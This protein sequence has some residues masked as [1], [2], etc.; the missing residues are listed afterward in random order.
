MEQGENGIEA[1]RSDD[2]QD[3]PREGRHGSGRRV[4][5]GLSRDGPGET[6]P[7][8]DRRAR[9]EEEEE[10]ALEV[11][12]CIPSHAPDELGGRESSGPIERHHDPARD[13]NLL[14]EDQER[15]PSGRRRRARHGRRLLAQEVQ[16]VRGGE[17]RIVLQDVVPRESPAEGLGQRRAER[18]RGQERQQDRRRG[19]QEDDRP[20]APDGVESGGEASPAFRRPHASAQTAWRRRP[21]A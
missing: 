5:E 19:Q 17:S 8:A 11:V 10:E 20:P 14:Q 3:A 15:G 13:Q 4:F 7:E 2:R 1:K 21:T 6:E 9:E 16:H 18:R 12:P